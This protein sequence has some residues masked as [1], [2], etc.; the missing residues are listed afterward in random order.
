MIY[1]GNNMKGTQTKKFTKQKVYV[2]ASFLLM[3]TM[4]VAFSLVY[5]NSNSKASTSRLNLSEK[6]LLLLNNYLY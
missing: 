4:V 3:I 2:I 5:T 1:G 6:Q